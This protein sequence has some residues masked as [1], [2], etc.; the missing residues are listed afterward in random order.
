MA[1]EN[2][3]VSSSVLYDNGT[4]HYINCECPITEGGPARINES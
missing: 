3:N 2:K 1:Q 4:D